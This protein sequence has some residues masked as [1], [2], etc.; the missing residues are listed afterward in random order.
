MAE[1]NDFRSK[2]IVLTIPGMDDA[3]VYRDLP[4]KEVDDVTLLADVYRP[5]SSATVPAV[6]CV[7]G[8]GPW[9]VLR[10]IKE[11]AV[12]QS[13]GRLIA[14]SGLAA[15]TFTHR[16][17]RDSGLPAVAQ[18]VDDLVAWVRDRGREYGI[19][20]NRLAIWVFSGGGPF[21]LRTAL[22][23]A[24]P[25]IRCIVAYY[26]LLDYRHVLEHMQFD[27]DE[28]PEE[29]SPAA[30]LAVHPGALPPIFVAKAGVD[31]PWLN[32]SIDRFV[33]GAL[34]RNLT[35]DLMT[36]PRGRHAFDVLNDDERSREIIRRTLAFLVEHL[37]A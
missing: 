13:F 5:P 36:H 22:R 9:E 20:P 10:E 8:D 32:E 33:A 34:E 23:N 7:S 25:Y 21:G 14:A 6:L 16:A 24:P 19:D 28:D 15:V 37:H 29:F 18:D 3:V 4:F 2:P 31:K 17:P 12:Y 26:S 35:L 30:Q 11:Y 1:P 27:P